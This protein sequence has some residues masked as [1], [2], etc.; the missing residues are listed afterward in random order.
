MS[1]S[2]SAL[3]R[4]LLAPTITAAALGALVVAGDTAAESQDG[5]S[6]V[7]SFYPA[8]SDRL[9]DRDLVGGIAGE[10]AEQPAASASARREDVSRAGAGRGGANRGGASGDMKRKNV[11]RRPALAPLRAVLP[12][13]HYEITATYAAAG[14]LWAEDHTGTDFA[15]PYGTRVQAVRSGRVESVGYDGAFGLRVVVRD[16]EGTRWWFCHLAE[17][18]VAPGDRVAA[19]GRLGGIGTSGNTTGPHLHLEVH[20]GGRTTDPAAWLAHLGL[21]A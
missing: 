5:L 1:P 9:D 3:R 15:A 8:G 2:L 10:G 19:G 12:V 13:Q 21:K 20:R 16:D 6:R 7:A 4:C 11:V 14:G 17:A 18:S